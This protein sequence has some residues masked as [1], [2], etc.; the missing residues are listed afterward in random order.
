M[1]KGYDGSV[2]KICRGRPLFISPTFPFLSTQFF[3]KE[4]EKRGVLLFL[5]QID[6]RCNEGVNKDLIELSR[7][8]GEYTNVFSRVWCERIKS[9]RQ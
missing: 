3:K 6:K 7:M 2:H 8:D 9:A 5:L 4:N 1:K